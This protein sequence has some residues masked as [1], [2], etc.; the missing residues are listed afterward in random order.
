MIFVL[1]QAGLAIGSFAIS[2]LS[3][4]YGRKRILVVSFVA[5]GLLTIAGAFA[6]SIMQLALLRA[7]S[8]LFLAGVVPTVLALVSE[9]TPHRH[10]ST[11]VG[12]TQAGYSAGNAMGA[13]VAFLVPL[14]GWQGAFWLGG[15]LA[16]LLVPFVMLFL[17]ES[18]AYLAARR[19]GDTRIATTLA[20]IDPTL[21]LDGDEVFVMPGRERSASSLMDVFSEGRALP[22]AAIW[23]CF[24]LSMGNI[25]LLASWLP[26]FFQSMAGISIQ[27][28]AV[29]LMVA[30]IGGLAGITTIGILMDRLRPIWLVAAYYLGNAS[31]LILIGHTPF[32]H[33]LFMPLL[34]LFAF[35]QSGG[36]GG[37]NILLTQ[38][39]PP[40][41][42]STGLGWAGGIG[43]IGG[44]A[45]PA[46]G[47][48]ALTNSLS[49]ELT[50]TLIA[51]SPMVVAALLLVV[52]R[53]THAA[54][55]RRLSRSSVAT[56]GGNSDPAR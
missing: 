36:Q 5:F 18:I 31:A 19:P 21:R 47:A 44:V 10:R 34:T 33:L 46:A 3:D 50:L 54:A 4:L 43:R 52:F 37:L 13:S 38:F 25:A 48:L 27:R 16:L 20:R 2:P 49:L 51:I 41:V 28:F 39:Y 29:A 1:Q 17:H 7:L 56:L 30:L 24:L 9:I 26:T 11:V 53:P 6:Q 40:S 22:T 32:D 14:F 35:F 45:A 15:V 55:L 23:I 12:I 42:R 8:G